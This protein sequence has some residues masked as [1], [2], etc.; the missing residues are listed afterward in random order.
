MGNADS[1]LTKR[2]N[3][4]N[5]RIRVGRVQHIRWLATMFCIW[6]FYRTCEVQIMTGGLKMLLANQ[7]FKLRSYFQSMRERTASAA[8]GG[9]PRP[10]YVRIRYRLRR[11]LV[12]SITIAIYTQLST[13]SN[14]GMNCAKPRLTCTAKWNYIGQFPCGSFRRAGL[15]PCLRLSEG[16]NVG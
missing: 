3:M 9:T 13:D 16:A 11:V 10:T 5:K 12:S 15:V 2:S 1:A 7:L 4:K 8:T 14:C 6:R